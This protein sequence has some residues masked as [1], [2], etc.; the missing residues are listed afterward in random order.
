MARRRSSI[1]DKHPL[2]DKYYKIRP[3][4]TEIL[5][6]LTAAHGLQFKMESAT[7]KGEKLVLRFAFVIPGDT[8]EAGQA[9]SYHEEKKKNLE[10]IEA[11]LGRTFYGKQVYIGGKA[12]KIIGATTKFCKRP[13]IGETVTGKLYR[14]PKE[15]VLAQVN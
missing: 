13:F 4:L 7:R 9:I 2:V 10:L 3:E 11:R 14:L 12:L 15:V 6:Q 1:N 5:S 8:S